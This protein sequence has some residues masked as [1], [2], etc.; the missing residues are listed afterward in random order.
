[1]IRCILTVNEWTCVIFK[2][3]QVHLTITF[4]CPFWLMI[5]EQTLFISMVETKMYFSY[6]NCLVQEQTVM[7][8][9]R[10]LTDVGSNS[11]TNV[12]NLWHSFK[13]YLEKMSFLR[14]GLWTVCRIFI[15][16]ITCVNV[17]VVARFSTAGG[18]MRVSTV[19]CRLS[20]FHLQ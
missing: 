8:N 2:C 7:L 17:F 14:G 19:R 13:I 12:E 20:H 11:L 5:L 4:L 6:C 9:L 16:G 1:M 15:I 18:S 3:V 10:T